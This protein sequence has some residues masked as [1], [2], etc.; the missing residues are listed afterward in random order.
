[1]VGPA[2]C[3]C[4]LCQHDDHVTTTSSKPGDSE[5]A[6]IETMYQ[7]A[8]MSLFDFYLYCNI[9]WLRFSTVGQPITPRTSEP[10]PC[11]D[12]LPGP[13]TSF[14]STTCPKTSCPRY[15]LHQDLVAI[16]ITLLASK[17]SPNTG[18]LTYTVSRHRIY[19]LCLRSRV[20]WHRLITLGEVII[21]LSVVYILSSQ[22][23][24]LRIRLYV[25]I[26]HLTFCHY[27]S[28]KRG[29]G[30]AIQS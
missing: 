10:K 30:I 6:S 17:W 21:L 3:I 27:V 29:I 25:L 18:D 13:R 15:H 22:H 9:L 23:H 4:H 16:I 12:H 8:L 11:S 14:P 26:D 24:I 2:R 5:N 20:T 28:R 1:M 7:T 19:W